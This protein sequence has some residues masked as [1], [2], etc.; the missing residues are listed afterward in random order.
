MAVLVLPFLVAGCGSHS[1]ASPTASTAVPPPVTAPPAPAAPQ[2]FW[3]LT[4]TYLGHT[5]P[6]ACIQPFD[7]GPQQPIQSVIAIR[8]SGDAIEV[9]TEHD[10]YTGTVTEDRVSAS[11]SDAGIWQ[12]GDA[13]IAYDSEG[14]VFGRFSADGRSFAGEEGV[15]FRLAS[16]DTITRR[17]QWSAVRQ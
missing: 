11:D 5:G 14:Y 17:W 2:D 1:P 16:G 10:H 13:R 3:T 8:R 7:G 6:A 15:A 12:C 9:L 4:G